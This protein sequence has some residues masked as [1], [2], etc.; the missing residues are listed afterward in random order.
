MRTSARSRVRSRANTSASSTA[1]C[2]QCGA[3]A[4]PSRAMPRSIRRCVRR[5]DP[6][7]HR[8]EVGE[9]G[10]SAADALDDQQRS[11]IHHDPLGELSG[12]PVVAAVGARPVLGEGSQQVVRAG[13]RPPAGRTSPGRGRPCAPRWPPG[14]AARSRPPR[15]SCPSRRGRR[16]R[17]G[18]RCRGSVGGPVASDRIS[19]GVGPGDAAGLTRRAPG[20]G[21]TARCRRSRRPASRCTRLVCSASSPDLACRNHTQSPICSSRAPGPVSG[22]CTSPAP[23][24]LVRCRSGG[25]HGIGSRSL[26]EA[27]LA[28]KPPP[29]TVAR[30]PPGR[31][32]TGR[33]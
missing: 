20:R 19:A 4:S 22:V 32:T 28:T 25:A 13:R 6:D 33:P 23:S 26:P 5:L 14:P 10:R 1:H 30:P 29:A 9:A 17:S 16:G 3:K 2:S 12:H 8:D 31:R 7:Q 11:G 24:R 15:S 27:P 18:G 21:R